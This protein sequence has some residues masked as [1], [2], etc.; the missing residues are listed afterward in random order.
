MGL[1]PDQIRKVYNHNKH[2]IY[3]RDIIGDAMT[4][5]H[6]PK[7]EAAHRGAY[8]YG[9]A[10]DHIYDLNESARKQLFRLCKSK[11]AL[12]NGVSIESKDLS[13][14]DK[15]EPV[16]CDELPEVLQ[17]GFVYCL[18]RDNLYSLYMNYLY[19]RKIYGSNLRAGVITKIKISDRC[20]IYAVPEGKSLYD[21]TQS[22]DIKFT[23]QSL[24]GLSMQYL[25]S[26]AELHRLDLPKSVM[27]KE[28]YDVINSRLAVAGAPNGTYKG[29]V[30]KGY[31]KRAIDFYRQYTSIAKMGKFYILN[32]LSTFKPFEGEFDRDHIYEIDTDENELFQGAGVYD[33]QL[34]EYGLKHGVITLENIKRWCEIEYVKDIDKAISIFIDSVYENYPA[35][36]KNLCNTLIGMLGSNKTEVSGASILTTS[37][38]EANYIRCK[39]ASAKIEEIVI[40]PPMGDQGETLY[41]VVPRY[42][43]VNLCTH[44][45]IRFAIVQRARMQTIS[46]VNELRKQGATVLAVQTD[47]ICFTMSKYA[48]TPDCAVVQKKSMVTFGEK[49]LEDK[50]KFPDSNDKTVLQHPRKYVEPAPARDWSVTYAN[51]NEYFNA[52]ALMSYKRCFVSGLAGTGKSHVLCDLR[53]LFEDAGKK[54][55][56]VSYTNIAAR[57][58]DG[59]TFHSALHLD[60]GLSSKECIKQFSKRYSVVLI[61]EISMVSMDIYKVLMQLPDE[62]TIIAFGD[63][64]QLPPVKDRYCENRETLATTCFHNDSAY[65]KF[66]HTDDKIRN[67]RCKKIKFTY[68][69]STMFKNLLGYNKIVLTKQCRSNQDYVKQCFQIY[70]GDRTQIPDGVHVGHTFDRNAQYHLCATNKQRILINSYVI[71]NDDTSIP[72]TQLGKRAV[73]RC[74]AC[75]DAYRKEAAKLKAKKLQIPLALAKQYFCDEDCTYKIDEFTHMFIGMRVIANCNKKKYSYVNSETGVVDAFHGDHVIV[76]FDTGV[77]AHI[78]N[79]V[80]YYEFCPA[81]AITVHKSQGL[82]IEGNV[83]LYETEKM[84][85]NHLY[86]ALTRVTDPSNIKVMHP[87]FSFKE[88]E[89]EPEPEVVED[90]PVIDMMA[91]I[92]DFNFDDF[93]PDIDEDDMCV[94]E[95]V[96]EKKEIPPSKPMYTT[97]GGRFY[98]TM[99][100]AYTFSYD[101]EVMVCREVKYKNNESTSYQFATF[102]DYPAW[103]KYLKDVPKEEQTFHEMS[104]GI[105]RLFID[106]DLKKLDLTDQMRIDE[107]NKELESVLREAAHDAAKIIS[108]GNVSPIKLYINSRP[109]KLSAHLLM[110]TMIG[111]EAAKRDFAMLVKERI[112]RINHPLIRADAEEIDTNVYGKNSHLRMPGSAKLSALKYPKPEGDVLLR[113]FDRSKC[114]TIN[115]RVFNDNV[116]TDTDEDEWMM[117]SDDEDDYTCDIPPAMASL[118][119]Q[120][121]LFKAHKLKSFKNGLVNFTRIKPSHCDICDRVHESDN[122][123]YVVKSG[124]GWAYGCTRVKGRL[125]SL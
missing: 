97:R 31:R 123:L 44:R 29:A 94:P 101:D 70:Q 78:P 117:E 81:Y 19:E 2:N 23:G 45:M 16:F 89:P 15:L 60:D 119:T 90:E 33:P 104:D 58:V 77:I 74:T 114:M 17:D 9:I 109:G 122:T 79:D 47:A 46:T 88:P 105:T 99:V 113:N 120:R 39:S 115:A 7:A 52:E 65:I 87:E 103:F 72:R 106:Y 83:C 26:I 66:A 51:E 98:S 8:Y 67:S 22:M 32:P 56:V 14:I 80:F 95:P 40:H 34:I 59:K 53:R 54:V 20:F 73:R 12:I 71:E 6:L 75:R 61:D 68:D 91:M 112:Q 42:D 116:S 4:V 30:E 11:Q 118:I 96:I 85:R 25:Q 37:K 86:T 76:T 121:S 35:Y 55:S 62:M 110:E 107:A 41:N 92:P 3:F 18:Q 5:E 93:S 82:T 50:D 49:R 69:K 48:K 63:F 21:M 108:N 36:A 102:F 1:T 124:I 125:I 10:N 43:K 28:T 111:D 24:G 100:E 64:S 84:T 57:L 38:D 13:E 27:N